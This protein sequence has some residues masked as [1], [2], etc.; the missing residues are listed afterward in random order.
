M[1][2][3]PEQTGVLI[4]THVMRRNDVIVHDISEQDGGLQCIE[5]DD[6]KI[7]LLF[8]DENGVDNIQIKLIVH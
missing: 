2:D 6:I 7:S 1:K 8:T 4:N 3:Q 5:V